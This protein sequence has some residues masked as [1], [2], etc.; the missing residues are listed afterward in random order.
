MSDQAAV[1][2]TSALSG[3]EGSISSGAGK[4]VDLLKDFNV[5]GFVL[6]LL[7]SNSVSDI[8]NSLIDSIIM[9]TIKPFLNRISRKNDTIEIGGFVLHLE[10]FINAIIKFLVL[11]I[12]IFIFVTLGVTVTKPVNWVKIQAINP[13]VKL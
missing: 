6:G 9:P 1:V 11:A 13:E 10:K 2:A 4:F 5:I 3:V 12:I 7:M 8:A